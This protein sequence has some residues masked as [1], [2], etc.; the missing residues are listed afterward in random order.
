[1][2]DAGPRLEHSLRELVPALAGEWDDVVARARRIEAE[3]SRRRRRLVL[4]AVAAAILLG[5]GTALAI[6]NQ[7]FG[8]FTVS[9]APQQA[10]SLPEAAPYVSGQTLYR[11]GEEPQRLASPLV[12]PLLG[13]YVTANLVSLVVSSPDRRYLAYHSWRAGTPL[14]F[15]HDTVTGDDRLLARGAQT[16]AWGAD[17]QI[18]YVRAERPRYSERRSYLGHVIVQAP[19]GKQVAWTPAGPYQVLAWAGDRLLVAVARC[20]LPNCPA[21]P[22]VGVYALRRP[23]ELVAL[24]LSGISALSPDG[25]LAIGRYDRA[26]GQ[27]SP[28]PLVRLVDVA[29]RRVLATID[30]TS[31]AR[32][33]GF[34]GLIAGS[35]QSAAWRDKTIVAAF[36]GEGGSALVVFRV[37]ARRLVVE[38]LFR[39]RSTTLPA[40]Y[41]V[42]FGPPSFIA[43]G[44][45]RVAMPVYGST[46]NDV[47]L[48]AV[49]TCDLESRDCVRGRQ[50]R[51]KEW[52]AVV[53]NPSRPLPGGR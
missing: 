41:G 53:E 14:L 38:R 5:T 1:M 15:V 10:P 22:G 44:T 49:L 29:Q 40:R 18:A 4:T 36:S 23:R 6:G 12:A 8:W 52:F 45:R 43:D 21:R 3:R 20:L 26:A 28:S 9:E 34:R 33:A 51:V 39:V 37:R 35:L 24:P 50:L 11:G 25:R 47:P 32:E 13:Q 17:G 16:L 27:D 46:S 30:L 19:G 2:S 48:A 31:A 42:S 7:L